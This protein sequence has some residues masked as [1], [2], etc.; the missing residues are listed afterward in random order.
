[1]MFRCENCGRIF[2]KDIMDW[3]ELAEV[4]CPYC[5]SRCVRRVFQQSMVW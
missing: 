1:M 5:G 2:K 4:K 3:R